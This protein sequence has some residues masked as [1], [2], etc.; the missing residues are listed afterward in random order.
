M[1]ALT[2]EAIAKALGGA[3]KSSSGWMARC[4]AHDDRNPSLSISETPDGA[5]LVHCHAGCPQENVVGTLKSRSLWPETNGRRHEPAAR[6]RKA[7]DKEEWVFA[8]P[9]PD[10]TPKP[11][12]HHRRLGKPSHVY[13]YRDVEG[14]VLGYV[15]RFDR[16]EGGKEVLPLTPWRLAGNGRIVWRWKAFPTPRPL[17]G[18]LTL[19]ERTGGTVVVVEGE[20]AAAAAMKLFPHCPV[21]TWPG[22]SKAYRMAD[23][24]P[25]EGR[26]T[27][28]FTDADEPGMAAAEGI[29]RLLME[30]GN[31]AGSIRI[32]DPPEGL[33]KGWDLADALEEGWDAARARAFA[34]ERLREPSCQPGEAISQPGEPSCQPGEA[35]PPPDDAPEGE[36]ASPLAQRF[37]IPLGY[38]HDQF[39]FHTRR[40]RQVLSFSGRGLRDKGNLLQLAPLQFW[41]REFPSERGFSGAAVDRAVNALVDVC[42]RAGV[43][44]PERIRGRGAWWDDGRVIMHLGDRLVVDGRE[45]D[46]TDIDSLYIYEAAPPIRRWADDPLPV[47][48]ARRFQE[49]CDMLLWKRPVY[50]TLLAGWCVVAPI[51]GSLAWRPHIW[52]TSA[53]GGGKSWVMDSIVRPV[54]GDLVLPVL[55][56]TT[57]AGI[58]QT[59]CRDARPILFDEAESENDK[60]SASLENVLALMRQASSDVGGQIIKGSTS[61]RALHFVIRSCFVFA[62]INTNVKQHADATRI[63]VLELL[64]D[65]SPEALEHFTQRVNPT[66]QRLLT[67]DYCLRLQARA[68]RHVKTIRANAETFAVA[69]AERLGSRRIGDQVGALLAGAYLLQSDDEVSAEEARRWIAERDWADQEEV[70]DEKDEERLLARLMELVCRVDLGNGKAAERSVGELVARAAEVGVEQDDP[71]RQV[72]AA[73]AL[74]RHG[75]KV[76]GDQLVISNTHSGIAAMLKG[77]PWESGW[78]KVLSRIEGATIGRTSFGRGVNCRTTNIPLSHIVKQGV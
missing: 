34:R 29:A 38:N 3:R 33:E 76:D 35:P 58:R 42:Y 39:Y 49:L 7:A 15:C 45:T 51:C 41:E 66:A 27:L 4:P 31:E 69:A 44:L 40:G 75:L 30:I 56:R 50:G 8:G 13:A 62:S 17:Y 73:K 52:I 48:E 28:I 74:M 68:M 10:G 22:G 46:I 37:F 63:A 47:E 23:W 20:K 55:G 26:K 54:L 57:E 16:P 77:T 5:P 2:I 11:D 53:A 21:V 24:S 14:R 9:A 12:F 71:V 36:V 72:D 43:F 64:K 60:A 6:R 70:L 25:L 18:L 67:K 78:G 59:L 65:N 32:V 19:T 1:N 61:G